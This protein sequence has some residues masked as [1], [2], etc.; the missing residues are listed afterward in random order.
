MS[1]RKKHKGASLAK[2]LRGR[3]MAPRTAEQ[4]HSKPERVQVLWD[5]VISVISEMRKDE[6]LSLQKASKEAGISPSTVKRWGGSALQKRPSGRWVP[7]RV[8]NLLRI[9]RMPAPDGMRDIGVRGLRKATLL[10]NYWAAVHGYL[11]TGNRSGLEEFRGKYL[12]A[13]DGEKVLLLTEPEELDRLG[14]AGVLSFESI[15]AR[16]A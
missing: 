13:A 3:A 5:K 16:S 7:K 15:Y 6:K 11:E 1:I 8:D 14:N 4:Y 12:N 2:K 9:L 10:S